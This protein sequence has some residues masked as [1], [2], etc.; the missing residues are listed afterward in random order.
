MFSLANG[1][2]SNRGGAFLPNFI[3]PC[4]CLILYYFASSS[5]CS[6]AVLFGRTIVVIFALSTDCVRGLCIL[7]H[8]CKDLL[9][10]PS[11]VAF[12]IVFCASAGN[13]AQKS[14]I[15][16]RSEEGII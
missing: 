1:Y 12:V 6:Y 10:T 5:S 8:S 4:I 9:R 11:L 13:E 3:L 2:I 14:T 7:E 16:R 15:R